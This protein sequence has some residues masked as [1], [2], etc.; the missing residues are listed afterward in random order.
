[1]SLAGRF[2]LSIVP[3]TTPAPS[4]VSI[5]ASYRSCDRRQAWAPERAQWCSLPKATP[6]TLWPCPASPVSLRRLCPPW[7]QFPE[8]RRPAG[9]LHC[10]T[11][12]VLLWRTVQSLLQDLPYQDLCRSG[13]TTIAGNLQSFFPS[14]LEHRG[15]AYSP[16][17]LYGPIVI[18]PIDP[19]AIPEI[20][21]LR[22][23]LHHVF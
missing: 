22:Q 15:A 16:Q 3:A 4:A 14:Y 23:S 2:Y 6:P 13:K 18:G 12:G 20:G 8:L 7:L 11:G 10:R 9:G 17:V 19:Y 5:E 21:L 1:M